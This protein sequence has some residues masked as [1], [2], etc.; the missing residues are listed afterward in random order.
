MRDLIPKH[1]SDLETANKLAQYSYKEIAEIVPELLEWIQDC[2]WP[3]AGPVGDYL[4]SISEDLTKD[5]I[6][7]LKGD[8]QVWKY[9]CVRLF[10]FGNSQIEPDLLNEFRRIADNPTK[11]EVTEEVFEEARELIGEIDGV[12]YPITVASTKEL[13][14]L[15][16]LE[17]VE[18]DDF[19]RTAKILENKL[20]CSIDY[21]IED[22]DS[23]YWDFSFNERK[24][25]LHYHAM[26]GNV[27]ILTEIK[28]GTIDL[29]S[30]YDQ[31]SKELLSTTNAKPNRL[32]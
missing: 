10:G 25:T 31:I 3:V 13:F 21:R 23:K 18:W 19:H 27:E 17:N 30:I 28:N 8:D 22:F 11:G 12:H 16:I 4:I 26:V 5:I 1:K 6:K 2:N 14:D 20:S 32:D 9:W 24:F 15:L 7:I 29:Q